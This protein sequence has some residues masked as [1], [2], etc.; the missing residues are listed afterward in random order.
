MLKDKLH[1]EIREE[2]E[3]EV[4]AFADA[5]RAEALQEL[6]EAKT[7][8]EKEAMFLAAAD[9]LGVTVIWK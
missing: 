7:P 3:R 8:E 1:G 9:V 2:W 5:I 6:K 4:D